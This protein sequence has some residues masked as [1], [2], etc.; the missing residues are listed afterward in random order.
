[1]SKPVRFDFREADRVPQVLAFDAWDR[2]KRKSNPW[3]GLKF[4]E[5]TNDRRS[6]NVAARHWPHLLC[7]QW[8]LIWSRPAPDGPRYGFKFYPARG[9]SVPRWTL[10]LLWMGYLHFQRQNYDRIAALGPAGEG[11]P[12]IYPRNDR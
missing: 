6:F 7:W 9:E 4:F 3:A 11:A 5:Q 10:H 12:V 2:A 1:M 8:L